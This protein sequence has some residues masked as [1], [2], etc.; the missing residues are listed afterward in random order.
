MSIGNKLGIKGYPFLL[1][2]IGKQGIM[3]RH[4]FLRIA[5]FMAFY[6][7]SCS[8]G[9]NPNCAIYYLPCGLCR[10]LIFFVLSFLELLVLFL[11]S[12]Q[13]PCPIFYV[14]A[15]MRSKVENFKCGFLHHAINLVPVM[16]T[17]QDYDREYTAHV[18]S[19][20]RNEVCFPVAFFLPW[21]NKA[22]VTKKS[23]V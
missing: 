14:H 19:P 1:N 7:T 17:L 5:S 12:S 10:L 15:C 6:P 18:S 2:I 11:I 20:F 13:Y 4:I 8:P 21:T 3:L 16:K 22:Q 9:D 23:W